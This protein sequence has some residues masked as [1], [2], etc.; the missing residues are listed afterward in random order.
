[1]RLRPL[2]FGG[3]LT[4][5]MTIYAGHFVTLGTLVLVTVVPVALAQYA[6]AVW[7][8]PRLEAVLEL[9]THPE[10][11]RAGHFPPLSVTALEWLAASVVFR[12]A[13][14]G[15]ALGAVG[16]AVAR[17]YRDEPAG[18]RTSYEPVLRRCAPLL[19]V[20]GISVMLLVSGYL[21][22]LLIVAIPLVVAAAFGPGLLAMVAPLAVLLVLLA[23]A[24]LLLVLEVTTACAVCSVVVEGLRLAASLRTTF[25]RICNRR[26]LGRALL[27]A[28]VVGAVGLTASTAVD[29]LAL[30]GFPRSPGAYVTLDAVQRVL[31]LPFLALVFVVYYFD[32]RVRHEGLDLEIGAE[33][34]LGIADEDEPAYAPTAYLSGEERRLVKRFLE[35]RDSLAPRQRREIAARLADRAR[36]RVPA[37]LQRLDDEGLLERL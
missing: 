33:T 4:R 14:L 29:T 35:R 24:F 8:E 5:A 17:I 6:I 11:L 12:Y 3:I 13:M 22:S 34:G 26:E 19:G 25:E 16:A 36:P 20:V 15:I 9:F 2:D 1:M 31:V 21:A 32:V 30:L 18:L 37:D 23:V 10:R 7:E 27:C 28:V